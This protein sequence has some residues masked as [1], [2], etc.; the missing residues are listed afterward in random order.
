[1]VQSDGDFAD[2]AAGPGLSRRLRVMLV[3]DHAILRQGLKA[4]LETDPRVQVVGEAGTVAEALA[5]INRLHPSVV[6]TD[7]GLPGATGIDLIAALQVQGCEI[8]ILVLT[9]MQS[10]VCLRAALRAGARGFMLKDSSHAELTEGLRAVAAGQKFMCT[11]LSRGILRDLADE[12][13]DDDAA[14][15]QLITRREREVLTRIAMGQS[16]KESARELRLSVK[17]VAKHRSN[18]M[19]KLKLHNSAAVTMFAMR[20]GLVGGGETGALERGPPLV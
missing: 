9:A 16:S 5:A 8:P 7:I 13:K 1:M 2:A 20:H 11:T 6:I 14:P 12:V 4:L 3:E 10:A 15:I 17:T 18:L 19:R